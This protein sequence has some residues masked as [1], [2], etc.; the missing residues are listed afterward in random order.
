MDTLAAANLSGKEMR[1]IV[2]SLEESAY[3]TP[4][5]WSEELRAKRIDLGGGS[6]LLLQGTQRL[7]GGTGN[8]QLFV[9]RKVNDAWVSLVASGQTLLVESFQFGPGVTGGIKDLTVQTNSGAQTDRR[10]TYK[11]DGRFYRR[12]ERRPRPAEFVGVVDPVD[13]QR[14]AG[15]TQPLEAKSTARQH[16]RERSAGRHRR[17]ACH[18][19]RE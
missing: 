2:A 17:C 6:G 18:A 9:F 16:G 1:Q 14:V 8:C 5:S 11:F 4:D 15:G 3:D 12:Q 7:C 10:K 19:G 13:R